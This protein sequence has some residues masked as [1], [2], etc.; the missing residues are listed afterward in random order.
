VSPP[1]AR[2]IPRFIADSAQ[3]GLPYGRWA[4]RVRQE[5]ARACEKLS[6]EA[7]ARLDP[8]SVFFF[9]ERGWGGRVYLP[10][11]GRPPEEADGSPTEFFGYVSFRRGDDDEPHDLRATADFTDVTADDN[12]DWKIDLNDEVIGAWR[13]DAGRGGDVTLVW[14]LPLVRGAIAATAELGA[15]VVDQTPIHEGRFTLVAVDAVKGFG[16]DLYLDVRLW[17]RRLG[18]LASESLYAEGEE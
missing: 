1:V 5:F 3:E 10:V 2:P 9:P 8:E 17:D 14:G 18:E 11:T 15:D 12:P 7:G 13:S 4:E 16:D 6:D